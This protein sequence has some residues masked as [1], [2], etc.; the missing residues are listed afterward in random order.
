MNPEVNH[1]LEGRV[2]LVAPTRRDGEV[3]CALL[4]KAGLT[5]IMCEGLAN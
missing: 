4:A 3:T 1:E 5:C 2:L